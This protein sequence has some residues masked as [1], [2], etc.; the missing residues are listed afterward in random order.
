LRS[1]SFP[2]A[3]SLDDLDLLDGVMDDDKLSRDAGGELSVDVDEPMPAYDDEDAV[4][5]EPEP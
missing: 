3:P 2:P 1:T 5:E 4:E